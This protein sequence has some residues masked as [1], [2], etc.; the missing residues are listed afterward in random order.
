MIG[1]SSCIGSTWVADVLGRTVLIK[2]RYFGIG[3]LDRLPL[4]RWY[5]LHELLRSTWVHSALVRLSFD[6]LCGLCLLVLSFDEELP[7]QPDT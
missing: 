6:V 7:L 2:R 1:R 4:I 5:K 3:L